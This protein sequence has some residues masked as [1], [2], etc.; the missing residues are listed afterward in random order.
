MTRKGYKQTAEHSAKIAVGMRG[1]KQSPAHIRNRRLVDR[2]I[3]WSS[4]R[5]ARQS[6][7]IKR[8]AGLDIE[9]NCY[10][11]SHNCKV[12]GLT[13]LL[14]EALNKMGFKVQPEANFGRRSIDVLLVDEW[15]AFEADGN[16]WHELNE[17]QIPGYH[18]IRDNELLETWN[19]PT[20]RLTEQEVRDLAKS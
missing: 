15:L 18:E 13:W 7:V 12:S 1:R 9:C 8:H 16:Y 11:H 14:A 10:V 3:P 5:K 17:N 19:L 2:Y 20:I 4:E 6:A